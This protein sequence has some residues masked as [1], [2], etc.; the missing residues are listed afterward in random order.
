MQ[1]IRPEA[2]TTSELIRIADIGFDPRQGLSVEW[3]REL[4]RRLEYIFPHPE[5]RSDVDPDTHR[6]YTA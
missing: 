3:Q 6:K 2:L 1:G 4:L 5:H